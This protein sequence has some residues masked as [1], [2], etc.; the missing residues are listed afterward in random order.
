MLRHGPARLRALQQRISASPASGTRLGLLLRHRR[1]AS[2]QSC[3]E[4]L[5]FAARDAQRLRAALLHYTLNPSF[6]VWAV[7][8]AMEI[9]RVVLFGGGSWGQA[10]HQQLQTA[11]VACVG[12][13]DNNPA[14]R[15]A[16][17]IT[18]PHYSEAEYIALPPLADAIVS[19][20]QGDHDRIVLPQLQER[21]GPA[22]PVLS[23]KMVFSLFTDP[24]PDALEPAT[25]THRS[26]I[27]DARS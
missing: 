14:T 26:V 1:S 7:L 6:N 16:A 18:A 8:P 10:L 23:W 15:E 27:T 24:A 20:I 3:A 21:L 17:L 19:T 22:V 4:A 25:V 11:A 5:Q 13:I 9:R 2:G 12:V